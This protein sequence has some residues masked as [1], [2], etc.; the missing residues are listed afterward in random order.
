MKAGECEKGYLKPFHPQTTIIED[1]R[2]IIYTRQSPTEGGQTAK[3]GNFEIYYRIVP[4]NA[5]C[6]LSMQCHINVEI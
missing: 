2:Q 3:K 1:S 6:L 4:Y 5:Q